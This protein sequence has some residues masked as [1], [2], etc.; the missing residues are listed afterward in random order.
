MKRAILPARRLR[1]RSGFHLKHWIGMLVCLAV[2]TALALGA[3]WFVSSG[4]TILRDHRI[5]DRGVPAADGS[6][7][8]KRQS[9]IGLAWLIAGYDAEVNYTDDRG[10]RYEGSVT[11]MTMLGGP[12]TDNA[13]LRYDPDHHDQFAVSWGIEASGAR[14]C[15]VIVLTLLLGLLALTSVY[16]AWLAIRA[17]RADA[18][19][20]ARG[21]E[22][23]LRVV[24]FKPVM[25]QPGSGEGAADRLRPESTGKWLF[26]LE[27]DREGQEPRRMT[28]EL[29]WP[30]YCAP[31]NARILALSDASTERLIILQHDG[32]PLALSSA[33]RLEVMRRAEAA[34]DRG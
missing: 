9:R 19:I 2:A 15:A 11:F 13:E 16:A 20:A 27:F 12:D 8:G 22:V 10:D 33:D 17:L 25:K 30:L 24:S 1:L 29:E 21:D 4:G 23:E 3:S 14:W 18:R 32:A 5:W 28:V 31:D 7:H 6:I 26:E 34:R